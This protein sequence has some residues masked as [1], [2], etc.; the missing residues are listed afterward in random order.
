MTSP[1][2]DAAETCGICGEPIE[3][4]PDAFSHG[5]THVEL[6]VEL[7]CGHSAEPSS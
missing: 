7:F 1:L 3:E 6:S 2:L 5:W 4:F